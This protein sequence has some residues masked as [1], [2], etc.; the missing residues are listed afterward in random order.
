[1]K[2]VGTILVLAGIA[3]LGWG[4]RHGGMSFTRQDKVIETG[5]AQGA[6]VK[7]HTLPLAPIAGGFCILAGVVII[8]AA[9]KQGADKDGAGHPG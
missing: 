3:G 2:F 5:D 7:T 8:V 6:L 4:V 1:M 9:S